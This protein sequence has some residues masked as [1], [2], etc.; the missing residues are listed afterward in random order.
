[1]LARDGIHLFKFYL[2]IGR[3]MQC[4]RF[5]ERRHDPL[6]GWKLTE[7]D[8]AAIGKWDDY[9]K[10]KEEMFRF[11]HTATSPWTVIRAN[12]KRRARLEVIR[13]VLAALDYEGKIEEDRRHARPPDR[14]LRPRLLLRRL[15]TACFPP[16]PASGEGTG[17]A[18][19]L[20]ISD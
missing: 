4:K 17:H 20:A 3:E 1:M 13:T 2:D 8:R 11:T 15:S 18:R 12:D 10:A 5:H 14:R 7:I 19:F 9:T 16:L 6:Q